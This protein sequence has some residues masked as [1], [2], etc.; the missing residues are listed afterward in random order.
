MLHV[1]IIINLN[2]KHKQVLLELQMYLCY[3]K[4]MLSEERP[5]P[6]QTHATIWDVP[7]AMAG[8]IKQI[9]HVARHDQLTGLL[10]KEAFRY[11]IEEHLQKDHAFGVIFMDMDAFKKVNDTL[12]HEEGDALLERFGEQL[13]GRFRREGDTLAH[14]K[15]IERPGDSK[16]EGVGRYGGDEFAIIIDLETDTTSDRRSQ[17]YQDH[18]ETMDKDVAYIRE[19]LDE[20]VAEQPAEVQ[21]CGF[22]IAV[23]YAIREPGDPVSASDILRAA[24]AAMYR[25]KEAHKQRVSQS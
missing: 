12:G 13:S 9:A 25:N 20:F 14:E 2:H 16:P 6:E 17:D 5:A 1:I 10:N 23:G 21:A 15:L 4:H 19:V 22:D 24:D 3:N 7:I 18:Q 8:V 11:E